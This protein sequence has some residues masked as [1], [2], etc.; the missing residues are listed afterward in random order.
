NQEL[1]IKTKILMNH[2]K[3]VSNQRANVLGPMVC[4][5]FALIFVLIP[6]WHLVVLAGIIGGLFHTKMSRGALTGLIGV[7]S[8]W[9]LNIFIELIST[10]VYTLMDQ[11]GGIILGNLGFGWL[12]IIVI[13]L[14]GIALGALGGAIGSGIHYFIELKK[15]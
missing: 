4:F 14:L 8:A 5:L 7:G 12:F 10:N 6:V 9:I 1:K 15:E 3:E 2:V 13:I 11:I